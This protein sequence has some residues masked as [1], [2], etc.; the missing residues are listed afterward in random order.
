MAAAW[1]ALLGCSKEEKAQVQTSTGPHV[2]KVDCLA[3]P[4]GIKGLSFGMTM[5]QA[6]DALGG[7]KLRPKRGLKYYPTVRSSTKVTSK[8]RRR[9]WRKATQIMPGTVAT[10]KTTLGTEPT[11]CTLAFAVDSKLSSISCKITTT[12]SRKKYRQV[13]SAIRTRLEKRHGAAE[14]AGPLLR[15]GDDKALLLLIGQSQGRGEI[16][17]TNQSGAHGDLIAKL[18][19]QANKAYAEVIATAEQTKAER[20]KAAADKKRDREK[21]WD[22]DLSATPE[23]Q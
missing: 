18:H 16:V 12:R 9:A 22:R 13:Y 2:C 3:V 17:L 5:G 21:S 10:V 11:V 23:S 20:A 14:I 7:A 15:W 1:I 19:E 8:L 4:T 6:K